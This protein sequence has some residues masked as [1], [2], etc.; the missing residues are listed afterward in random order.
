[1]DEWTIS[2]FGLALVNPKAIVAYDQSTQMM[3]LL[4]PDTMVLIVA[5]GA[6]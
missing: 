3:M 1:M 4:D 5:M 6:P 2:A